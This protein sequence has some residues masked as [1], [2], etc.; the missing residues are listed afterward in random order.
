MIDKDIVS[1]LLDMV[2]QMAARSGGSFD[3]AMAL[4]VERQARQQYGGS[5]EYVK[6]RESTHEAK[7]TEMVREYL[8]GKEVGEV[9]RR[10]GVSRASL[11]RHL[12]K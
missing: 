3:E 4:E 12:K 6:K 11:Y 7:K 10:H 9:T 8:D 1:T 5:E 2:L